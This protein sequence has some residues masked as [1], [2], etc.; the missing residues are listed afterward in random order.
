EASLNFYVQQKWVFT[1]M[2]IDT[3]Q[4]KKSKDGT[5][6]GDV[7]PTRFQFASEKLIYPVKITQISVK[8]KTEALFYVQ[9][10]GKIDLPGDFTYQYQWV[11]MIQ[12]ARGTGTKLRDLPGNGNQWLASIQDQVPA[13]KQRSQQLGFV[14][15]SGQ[16][17]GPGAQGHIPTTMEW[18]RK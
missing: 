18:A 9:A 4:M 17:P 3:M 15:R 12:T 5:Y 10:P 6:T 16:R 1:V 14:F 2:K 7:T 11:P 13:L 8:E